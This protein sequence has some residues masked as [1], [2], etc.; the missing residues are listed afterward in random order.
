VEDVSPFEES[1][2]Q[3]SAASMK[4]VGFDGLY[5]PPDEQRVLLEA[6]NIGGKV[7]LMRISKHLNLGREAA[8]ALYFGVMPCPSLNRFKK[9]SSH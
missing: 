9:S 7:M 8:Q 4:V 5:S 3:V 6:E 2:L 1:H